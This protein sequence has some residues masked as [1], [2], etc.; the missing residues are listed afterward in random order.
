MTPAP[1]RDTVLARGD[2]QWARL[3]RALDARLHEPLGPD[4]DWTGHDVYAH[5]ARWQELTIAA[6]RTLV[7]GGRP[8]DP[9]AHEDVLNVRWRA[10]DRATPTDAVRNRCLVS[11]AAL[12]TMLAALPREQWEAFGHVCAA[13]IDGSHYEH[14]LA[15]CAPELV[16]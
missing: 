12:G 4:T 15:V 1:D 8:A 5:F 11:R 2:E 10:E 3:R 6:V 7:A 16:A 13:D 14:H 9:E